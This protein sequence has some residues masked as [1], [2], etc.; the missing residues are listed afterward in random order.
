MLHSMQS[1]YAHSDFFTFSLFRITSCSMH[2]KPINRP[3]LG[4]VKYKNSSIFELSGN[5]V[6]G[7]KLNRILT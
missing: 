6:L 5:Q 7:K 2:L 4:I 1:I 3:V